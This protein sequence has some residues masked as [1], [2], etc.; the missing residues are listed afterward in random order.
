MFF[1]NLFTS[2]LEEKFISPIIRQP[3]KGVAQITQSILRN[4]NRVLTISSLINDIHGIQDVCLSLPAVVNRQG[5]TRVL[6]LSLNQTELQQLQHSSKILRQ[7]I[8]QMEKGVGE[9]LSDD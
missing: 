3:R 8:E 7:T 6:N 4:Q 9:L 2:S 5:V 1:E